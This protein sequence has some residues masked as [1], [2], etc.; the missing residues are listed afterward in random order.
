MVSRV[1]L[2]GTSTSYWFTEGFCA[3]IRSFAFG[4]LGFVSFDELLQTAC[5][6]DLLFGDFRLWAVGA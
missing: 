4:L 3:S 1:G 6:R 2:P 5:D